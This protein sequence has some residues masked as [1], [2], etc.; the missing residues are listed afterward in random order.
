IKRYNARALVENDEVSF[1]E[2]MKAKGDAHYL[3]KQPEW[4]KEIIPN[5]TVIR[6]Y[7]VSRS[8][9][10]VRNF[11][12]TLWKAY[13]EEE[14]LTE[15]DDQGNITKQI[16]GVHRV[17]DPL[18]LEETIQYDDKEGNFDRIIAAELA[19]AQAV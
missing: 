11:L 8:A 6:E 19:L 3:E 16:L 15:T 12:H 13:L 18:L 5:S 9:E 1:I 4:L 2:Y 14:L 7:G 10:K 17:L